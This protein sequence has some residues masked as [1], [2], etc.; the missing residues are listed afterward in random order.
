MI[1]CKIQSF[2]IRKYL[3]SAY[4]RD[5]HIPNYYAGN[6]KDYSQREANNLRGLSWTK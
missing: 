6:K 4:F 5:S 3:Q 2:P 1:L